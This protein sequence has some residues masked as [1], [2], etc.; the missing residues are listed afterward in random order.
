[1]ASS[2]SP[3]RSTEWFSE[4][5]GKVTASCIYKVMARTKTGYGADRANYAAQL[6]AERLT[7]LPAETFTNAAMVW[8]IETE[9]QARAIFAIVDVAEV[10]RARDP[11]RGTRHEARR[12]ATAT[13]SV[14]RGAHVERAHRDPERR[15]RRLHGAADAEEPWLAPPSSRAGT[16]T[17]RGAAASSTCRSRRRSRSGRSAWRSSCAPRRAAAT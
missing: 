5:A 16:A 11:E 7:G 14:A 6:V 13:G 10:R 2:P 17:S 4:R 9:A 8:G 15:R 12:R 1:M 3:Q